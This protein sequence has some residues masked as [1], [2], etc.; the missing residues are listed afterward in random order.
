LQWKWCTEN[1]YC[2]S[3]SSTV[4]IVVFVNI[5]YITVYQKIHDFFFNWSWGDKNWLKPL[6]G[7]V[8]AAVV[9]IPFYPNLMKLHVVS[10]G[11]AALDILMGT[12]ADHVL[13][14]VILMIIATSLISGTGGS[15]GLFMP[16]MMVG[17]FLG[18]IVG[19]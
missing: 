14:A 16:V 19:S 13:G 1:T 7:M 17:A 10:G 5:A 9:V 11:H 15:G 8:A 6:F 2:I 12:P 3:G 4:L 18:A